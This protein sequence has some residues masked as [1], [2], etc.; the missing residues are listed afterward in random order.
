MTNTSAIGIRNEVRGLSAPNGF[1]WAQAG[2][3][4][5]IIPL[6]RRPFPTLWAAEIAADY[7][8][9]RPNCN[10]AI[11]APPGLKSRARGPCDPAGRPLRVRRTRQ[12]HVQT[13][14]PSS[15]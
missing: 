15:S 2:V 3:T 4:N 14:P 13:Q 12:G 5:I 11:P 8:R 1:A 9:E 7:S 6:L 10:D